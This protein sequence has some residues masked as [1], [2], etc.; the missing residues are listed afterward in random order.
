MRLGRIDESGKGKTCGYVAGGVLYLSETGT[1]RNIQ[2][3]RFP[4]WRGIALFMNSSVI[5]RYHGPLSLNVVMDHYP[6][7]AL[8]NDRH[9]PSLR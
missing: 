1:L 2:D 4:A 7:L 8:M 5:G 3:S 6:P 9:G